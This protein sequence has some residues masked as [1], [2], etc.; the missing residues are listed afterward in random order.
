MGIL[1]VSCLAF[2]LSE[3]TLELNVLGIFL[4]KTKFYGSFIGDFS[5]WSNCGTRFSAVMSASSSAITCRNGCF[6]LPLAEQAEQTEW[7]AEWVVVAMT[8]PVV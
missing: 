6:Y 2:K 4:A 5:W 7:N 1:L 8:A 3:S